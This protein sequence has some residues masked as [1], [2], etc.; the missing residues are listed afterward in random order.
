[1]NSATAPL[2]PIELALVKALTAALVKELRDAKTP[3]NAGRVACG[4]SGNGGQ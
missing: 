2:T 4:M 1:M 3:E